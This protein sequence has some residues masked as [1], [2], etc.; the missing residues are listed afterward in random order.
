[1]RI[2]LVDPVRDV[3]IRPLVAR[4]R[5]ARWGNVS[6]LYATLL[7]APEVASAWADLGTAIRKRTSL[8][9]R[10]RELAICLVAHRCGQSY[11][12]Q[13]HAPLARDA[14]V[15][16]AE[17]DALGDRDACP[18]FSARERAVLDLV[19]ATVEGAVTDELVTGAGLTHGEVVEVVA[20]AAYYLATARYLDAIGIQ[21]GT[22]GLPDTEEDPPS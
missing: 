14:G 8:D 13:Q 6:P 5:G 12:W 18:S 15:T 20:T 2:P 17:L 19:E 10:T 9:D 1:M 3:A 7:Q 21:A 16:E 4:I 22:P 11:E